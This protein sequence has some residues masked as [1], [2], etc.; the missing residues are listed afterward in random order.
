MIPASRAHHH[1]RQR[2]HASRNCTLILQ[3][4]CR[5]IPEISQPG[6]RSPRP[7]RHP[8]P[9]SHHRLPL[10]LA[11]AIA[12]RSLAHLHGRRS[13]VRR[14]VRFAGVPPLLVGA[15]VRLPDF[16]LDIPLPDRHLL[17]LAKLPEMAEYCLDIRIHN[18]LDPFPLRPGTTLAM[19]HGLSMIEPNCNRPV[20]RLYP[21]APIIT[22][23]NQRS[24]PY[25][26]PTTPLP[27][28]PN[29]L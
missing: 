22:S 3:P 19:V 11:P 29:M 2:F 24:I 27:H 9:A 13:Q 20:S 15:V 25:R 18:M 6:G 23:S 21:P 8:D 10:L 28:Y 17:S 26:L 7:C 5:F 12:N 4:N 14:T 16:L 1:N